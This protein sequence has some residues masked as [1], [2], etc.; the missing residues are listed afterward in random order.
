MSQSKITSIDDVVRRLNQ[1][2]E[3]SQ[4]ELDLCKK[5]LLEYQKANNLSLEDLD[6]LSF[7]DSTWVFDR[8][9]MTFDVSPHKIHQHMYEL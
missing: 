8:V 7:E 6:D 4:E 9:F 3:R 2:L 5:W 1:G